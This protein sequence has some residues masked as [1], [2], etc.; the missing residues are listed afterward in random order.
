MVVSCRNSYYNELMIKNRLLKKQKSP[1][2]EIQREQ[3]IYDA[4][5]INKD[6]RGNEKL[7]QQ[8]ERRFYHLTLPYKVPVSY[9]I[10]AILMDFV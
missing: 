3:T 6:R 4:C 9:N 8:Q 2:N 7:V 5:D 1:R 10:C